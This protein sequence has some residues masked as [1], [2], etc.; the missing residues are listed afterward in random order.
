VIAPT[1]ISYG[2]RKPSSA[3]FSF[4]YQASTMNYSGVIVTFCALAICGCAGRIEI[5]SVRSTTYD[6]MPHKMLIVA[7]GGFGGAE[8]QLK[9]LLEGTLKSC[10]VDAQL[11]NLPTAAIEI[12]QDSAKK[13]A[14]D[15]LVTIIPTKSVFGS[16]ANVTYVIQLTDLPSKAT[17]WKAQTT[18]PPGAQ[19]VQPLA[20]AMLTSMTA[21]RII[22]ASCAPSEK[23]YKILQTH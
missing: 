10:G 21:D 15:A 3:S 13:F 18:V 2:S 1:M 11:F 20:D 9:S 16:Y 5:Q 7:A 14:A 12:P 17:A 23:N 19:A 4:R 8:E 22:P 6:R